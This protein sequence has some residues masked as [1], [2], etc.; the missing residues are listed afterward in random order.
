MGET[1]CVSW[2]FEKKGI[3]LVNNNV[4]VE[5]EFM[6]LVLDAVQRISKQ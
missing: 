4:C 5:D 1:G 3:I 2:M 6:M